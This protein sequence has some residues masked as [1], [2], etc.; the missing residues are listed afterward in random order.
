LDFFFC[1]FPINS[2]FSPDSSVKQFFHKFLYNLK[3]TKMQIAHKVYDEMPQALFYKIP[4][5]MKLD[6][7]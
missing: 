7:I 1:F 3:E 2:L 5:Q 6:S 4:F